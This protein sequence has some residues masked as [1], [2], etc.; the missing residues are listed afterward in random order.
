[1]EWICTA[2]YISIRPSIGA[3]ACLLEHGSGRGEGV[4][5]DAVRHSPVHHLCSNTTTTTTTTAST[6]RHSTRSSGVSFHQCI[7]YT[8]SS[9]GV[10]PSGACT[11]RHEQNVKV[12]NMVMD[13][14]SF[15]Q[16]AP[17][18]TLSFLSLGINSG[19]HGLLT[20]PALS[21]P[22]SP[23]VTAL[24]SNHTIK[25]ICNFQD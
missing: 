23:R 25:Y 8:S 11:A 15:C 24:W 2:P 18:D 14:T 7:V 20:R 9:L 17:R 3:S 19:G 6:W 4:W 1:M 12:M 16:R 22:R 5:C 10:W 21:R 13:T